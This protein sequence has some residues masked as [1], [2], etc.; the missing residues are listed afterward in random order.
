M[1]NNINFYDSA[2]H[3]MSQSE[4]QKLFEL[5]IKVLP[6]T[7]HEPKS[8]SSQ[9]AGPSESNSAVER[10]ATSK[11]YRL[12]VESSAKFIEVKRK[13]A[14]Q[15]NIFPN[16]QEWY[17]HQ[18]HYDANSESNAASSSEYLNQLANSIN[19]ETSSIEGLID[20]GKL[21]NIPLTLIIE[22]KSTLEYMCIYMDDLIGMPEQ[23]TSSQDLPPRTSSINE[24]S[25]VKM[26]FVVVN[27][28]PQ[29]QPRLTDYKG[30]IDDEDIEID[31]DFPQPPASMAIVDLTREPSIEELSTSPIAIAGTS[32][33]RTSQTVNTSTNQTKISDADYDEDVIIEDEDHY[34]IVDPN[35]DEDDDVG[36]LADDTDHRIKPKKHKGNYPNLLT[37]IF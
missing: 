34:D 37:R 29:N 33:P 14:I 1:D 8:P 15:T 5:Y 3:A 20:E 31:E 18:L 27:K 23:T 12:N 13:L 11:I 32:I 16:N 2:T 30:V 19:P 4:S 10:A 22:E 25:V 35:D 9:A 21:F 17:L 6:V 26:L 7:S 36:F 28:T 24:A